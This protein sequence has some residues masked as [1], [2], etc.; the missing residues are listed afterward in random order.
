M[1]AIESIRAQP[2]VISPEELKE[3]HLD[4]LGIAQNFPSR[5]HFVFITFGPLNLLALRA[6]LAL[7][8]LT[9]CVWCTPPVTPGT[10]VTSIVMVFST[11]QRELYVVNFLRSLGIARYPCQSSCL[12]DC[13]RPAKLRAND[14]S[15]VSQ[16]MRYGG[17]SD[18][19]DLLYS[20]I[21]NDRVASDFIKPFVTRHVAAMFLKDHYLMQGR[22]FGNEDLQQKLD[23]EFPS[24]VRVISTTPQ[25]PIFTAEPPIPPPAP[26]L[27]AKPLPADVGMPAFELS[28]PAL[29][30][31]LNPPPRKIA[32][33][34][35]LKPWE[36]V[37]PPLKSR[38]LVLP[39]LR[40]T[41][42]FGEPATI[43]T[44]R[45]A[46]DSPVGCKR[47]AGDA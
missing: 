10:F 43:P 12:L 22:V 27:A 9:D 15:H 23:R 6:A 47:G 42:A 25:V 1:K 4:L 5:K 37:L 21:R 31:P 14:R 34:S 20:A 39:P 30:H 33:I 28:Q 7:K 40:L 29:L 44:E 16:S 2:S 41:T 24:G 8:D 18:F 26:V 13:F 38:N 17:L 46:F 32:A 36:L 45:T 19:N 11:P 3:R 35:P